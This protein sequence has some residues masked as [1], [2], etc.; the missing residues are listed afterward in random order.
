MC[1]EGVD[2]RFSLNGEHL[3]WPLDPSQ[4]E[5]DYPVVD[6]S[7][8]PTV[9]C[10]LATARLGHRSPGCRGLRRPP[11]GTVTACY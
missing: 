4:V 3:A 9:V 7:P 2:A 6:A 8:H 11:D 1:A 10:A 5:I